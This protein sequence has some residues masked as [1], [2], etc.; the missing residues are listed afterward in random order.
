MKRLLLLIV[1]VSCWGMLALNAQNIKVT[2]QPPIAEMMDRF[3]SINKSKQFVPGW[4]I[5]ILATS[6]RQRLESERQAFQ[7]KY[8]N[9]TVDWIHSNPYFKLRAGAFATKLEAMRLKHILESEY[10]GLYL[11]KDDKIKPSQFLNSF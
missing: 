8:P 11:V 1:F 5:Q 7:Y 4:R 2:E 10:T 6:D 9:I 3:V